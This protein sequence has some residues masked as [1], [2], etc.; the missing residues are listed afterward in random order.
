MLLD[1]VRF[2]QFK[3]G[4]VEKLQVKDLEINSLSNTVISLSFEIKPLILGPSEPIVEGVKP[5]KKGLNISWRTDVT[6]KQEKYIV[7]YTRNDTKQSVNI[8]TTEKVAQLRELYPGAEYK[9]QVRK[10]NI[11]YFIVTV[12][13]WGNMNAWM[14]ITHYLSKQNKIDSRL[15]P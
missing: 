4:I 6:S 5:I 9:I 8:E 3:F 12:M 7:V 13:N 2:Q 14:L 11:F 15:V 1:E 10:D